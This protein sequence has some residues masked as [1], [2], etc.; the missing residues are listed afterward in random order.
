VLAERWFGG[1][2]RYR[3][4]VYI[5]LGEGISAG[6]ILDDKILNGY[7]GY[8]GQ[9]RHMVIQKGRILCNC[10]KTVAVLNLFAVYQR[11][12]AKRNQKCR[13]SAVMIR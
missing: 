13:L 6:I 11:F 7:Q 1:G 2:I 8:I 4:L 12:C 3:D 5:N 9:I 10:G